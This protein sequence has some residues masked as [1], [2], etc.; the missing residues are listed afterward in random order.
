MMGGGGGI[1][2]YYKT[3]GLVICLSP[4]LSAKQNKGYYWQK[5]KG[6][7]ALVGGSGGGGGV[8]YLLAR[9]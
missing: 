2:Q 4:R 7:V 5:I 8:L 3:I 9:M 6:E 1:P